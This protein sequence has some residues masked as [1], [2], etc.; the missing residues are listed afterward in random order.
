[1][2]EA[3]DVGGIG[4]LMLILLFMFMLMLDVLMLMLADVFIPITS[5]RLASWYISGL[6]LAVIEG[7][8]E[9][10]D[11]AALRLLG[12]PLIRLSIICVAAENCGT[13]NGRDDGDEEARAREGVEGVGVIAFGTADAGVVACACPD[14]RAPGPGFD[15]LETTEAFAAAASGTWLPFDVESAIIRAEVR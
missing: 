14:P 8:V 12:S 6:I 10:E 15:M 9:A 1:M 11:R 3:A 7:E 13:Y 5:L 4:M 2:G